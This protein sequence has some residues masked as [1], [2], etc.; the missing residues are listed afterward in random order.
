MEGV[1]RACGARAD[2]C[3]DKQGVRVL[4]WAAWRSWTCSPEGI[5]RRRPIHK[6]RWERQQPMSALFFAS[7]RPHM[8]LMKSLFLQ[9]REMAT[10]TIGHIV[11]TPS[12][13]IKQATQHAAGLRPAPSP[14]SDLKRSSSHLVKR[15][16]APSIA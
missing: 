10:V 2:G 15:C 8:G 9:H 6:Y 12:R 7:L 14:R 4:D 11:C 3:Q 1:G 5:L 13:H 16:V